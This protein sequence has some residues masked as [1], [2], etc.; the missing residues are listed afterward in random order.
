MSQSSSLAPYGLPTIAVCLFLV[1]SAHA[2]EPTP[3]PAPES[4][5]V[6][7]EEGGTDLL[8]FG[9]LEGS[10]RL[11]FV[12]FS[13]GFESKPQF[14]QSLLARTPSPW[15]S[16]DLLGLDFATRGLSWS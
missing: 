13:E 7:D 10:I 15:L 12:A 11:G 3:P 14:S 1:R 6:Q 9:R 5:P 2:Q 16:R 8:D 4:T